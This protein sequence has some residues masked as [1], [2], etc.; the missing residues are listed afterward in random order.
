MKNSVYDNFVNQKFGRL[1]VIK[2]IEDKPC[3]KYSRP[4]F[5]CLCECGNYKNV[6]GKYLKNGDVKSC[7][8]LSKDILIERNKKNKKFNTYDMSNDYGILWNEE[9]TCCFK[10]D[11]EDYD[12][13]KDIYWNDH[14][15]YAYGGNFENTHL[16]MHRY[17]MNINDP[18]YDVDHINHDTRDNRKNNLRIVTH[19]QNLFNMKLRK[20]NTSGIIGV[21]FNNDKWTSYI[22][23]NGKTI[24]LGQFSNKEDAINARKIAEEEYFGEFSYSNS[25][26]LF[27]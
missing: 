12:K 22:C 13:I 6:L 23:Y 9:H 21:C 8:C 20:D 3:G 14:K 5:L 18:N 25:L 19:Q 10:F 26:N 24:N 16:A 7:G 17:L 15:G 27:I 1:T 11:K 2:R 4:Q